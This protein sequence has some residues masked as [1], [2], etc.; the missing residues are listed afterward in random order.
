MSPL[1][2]VVGRRLITTVGVPRVDK[3]DLTYDVRDCPDSVSA[4]DEP[5][6]E[7]YVW[8]YEY[9]GNELVYY[10][11]DQEDYLQEDWDIDGE[12]E[13][14]DDEDQNAYLQEVGIRLDG[15]DDGD[16]QDTLQEYEEAEG[17]QGEY[18]DDQDVY[19]LEN[20]EAESGQ[21]EY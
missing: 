18:Y 4:V 5:Y 9:A 10:D 14:V 12:P 21:G 8:E 11:E 15:E 2:A 13:G 17:E 19:H 20:E 1:A 16:Q 7:Q 3:S 6:E